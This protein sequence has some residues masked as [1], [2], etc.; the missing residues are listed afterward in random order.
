MNIR[1]LKPKMLLEIVH[2]SQNTIQISEIGI[3]QFNTPLIL[4]KE[5]FHILL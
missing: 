1:K 4:G 2:S 5:K 3:N